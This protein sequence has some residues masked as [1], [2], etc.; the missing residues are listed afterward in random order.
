MRYIIL[1]LIL[2]TFFQ[3]FFW[4]TQDHQV[5]LTQDSSDKIQ[6]LSYS[7]YFGYE[8]K[9]LTSQRIQK[10]LELLSSLTTLFLFP[11][12]DDDLVCHI[13][14]IPYAT[15]RTLSDIFSSNL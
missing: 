8:K 1:G 5:T 4:I 2:A 11:D 3:L 13:C 15:Q 7:P 6:S 9:V 10:D 12:P 14:Y